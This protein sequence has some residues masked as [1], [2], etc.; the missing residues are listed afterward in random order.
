MTTLCRHYP[1]PHGCGG[2]EWLHGCRFCKEKK[3]MSES[4][5]ESVKLAAERAVLKFIGDPGTWL[6]P[7]YEG[8]MKIPPSWIA[9]CWRLVD[10]KKVQQQVAELIEAE[11]AQRIVNA[12][13]AELATDIKQVLSVQERRE[14]IR[15]VARD[16]MD[17]IL[18]GK[19][20]APEA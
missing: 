15:A 18:R 20:D 19:P 10:A 9:E 12:I 14:A 2:G 11:L 4:F 17:V 1:G 5:E 8:R 16:N 3:S 6:L 13:A 7:N